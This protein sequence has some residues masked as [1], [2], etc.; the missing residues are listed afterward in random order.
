MNGIPKRRSYLPFI[1]QFRGFPGQQEF[2]IGINQLQ[3]GVH[4]IW[5]IHIKHAACKV[6]DRYDLLF[7]TYYNTCDGTSD[8]CFFRCYLADGP[9]MRELP[10]TLNRWVG[11]DESWFLVAQGFVFING[12]RYLAFN[13]KTE[14]HEHSQ[15]GMVSKYKLIKAVQEYYPIAKADVAASVATE[16][17]IQMNQTRW[18]SIVYFRPCS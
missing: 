11:A 3:I 8:A 13:T 6:D 15:D 2:N 17:I 7:P 1:D 12:E 10:C 9:F 5:I 18:P 14:L 16:Q 4:F